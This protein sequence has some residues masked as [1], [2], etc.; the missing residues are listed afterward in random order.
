MEGQNLLNVKRKAISRSYSESGAAR[1]S[2]G[3]LW[4]KEK[5]RLLKEPLFLHK[6]KEGKP[7]VFDTVER[8][9]AMDKRIKSG[10][11]KTIQ[12]QSESRLLGLKSFR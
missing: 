1:P 6:H 9:E 8:N 10:V 4:K 7:S 2:A 5:E 11:F 3:E 12:I